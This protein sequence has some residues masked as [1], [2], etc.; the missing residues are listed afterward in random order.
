[1][2]LFS[3]FV[4]DPIKSLIKSFKIPTI[5]ATVP[6]SPSP[7][8]TTPAGAASDIIATLE[9]GIQNAVDTVIND[10]LGPLGAVTV[11]AANAFLAVIEQHVAAYVA[12][13]FEHARGQVA[14]NS[15]ASSITITT[16]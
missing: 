3:K 7:T 16:K 9:N 12:A 1:M 2:S 4:F 8:V 11:P 13:A 15:P 6:G 5:T 14:A 10:T